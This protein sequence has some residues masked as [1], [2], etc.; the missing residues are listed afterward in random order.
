MFKLHCFELDGTDPQQRQEDIEG[1]YL[2]VIFVED[3]IDELHLRSSVDLFERLCLL[4][5]H[6]KVL[7]PSAQLLK[8]TFC[9]LYR[10]SVRPFKEGE[11]LL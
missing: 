4:G 2:L 1:D 10:T 11:V 6:S 8:Q 5:L 7:R 9:L 3:L